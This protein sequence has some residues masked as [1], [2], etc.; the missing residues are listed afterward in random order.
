MQKS[1]GAG[2]TN[3]KPWK[4]AAVM[5]F[6][7]PFME[8]T[9]SSSNFQRPASATTSS[10]SQVRE[11]EIEQPDSGPGTPASEARPSPASQAAST[12]QSP[13]SS[14]RKRVRKE[15]MSAFEERMLGVFEVP[16]AAP[17]PP[18]DE[19]ELLKKSILPAMK[20]MPPAKL[21]EFKFTIH[22]MIFEADMQAT[23]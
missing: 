14:G 15:W 12:S 20:R 17:L 16:A 23:Q 22:R 6:L 11:E 4:N 8:Y 9:D 3:Y 2:L 18:P 1:S 10:V 5:G 7:A 19:D 13:A 21:A